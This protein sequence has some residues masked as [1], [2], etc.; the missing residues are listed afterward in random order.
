MTVESIQQ[1]LLRVRPPRVRITY[2]VETG[3]SAEKVELAFIVGI[4]ANL[5]GELDSS[6]LPM[7]K[8]RRMRDID[9]E[10]FDNILAESMP[11]IKLGAIP[12]LIK[13]NNANLQGTLTFTQL[14]D[15]EPLSVV[16]NVPSL[17]TRFDARADLRGLQSMAECNDSLAAVL[18]QSL[19]DGPAM[20]ALKTSFSTNVPGDWVAV[21]VSPSSTP[22]LA[23]TGA[24][25]PVGLV[26]LLSAQMAGNADAAAAA[27]QAATAAQTAATAAETANTTAAAAVEPAQTAVTTRPL[28][29]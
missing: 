11:T 22:V 4:F 29:R 26:T 5:S 2:D 8:D 24:D 17:K 13:G 9:S 21:S 12:D 27:Q 1:K 6:Q 19:I 10:T 20:T 14:A 16:N 3:G 15:F 25:L 7:L 23:P 28:P 18:D